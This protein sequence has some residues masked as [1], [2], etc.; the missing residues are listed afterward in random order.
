[1]RTTWGEFCKSLSLSRWLD[2]N[3]PISLL[4]CCL[5]S[6]PSIWILLWCYFLVSLSHCLLTFLWHLKEKSLSP[7]HSPS[8]RCVLIVEPSFLLFLHHHRDH[9]VCNVSSLTCL[10][11]LL[12]KRLFA[13]ILSLLLVV[14]T[15]PYLTHSLLIFFSDIHSLSLIHVPFCCGSS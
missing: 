6:F 12:E 8:L 11:H 5:F 7:L 15:Y 4:L 10:S 14:R 13:F 1:M 2:H 3:H 9:R